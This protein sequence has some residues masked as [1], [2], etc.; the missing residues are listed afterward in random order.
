MSK[1]NP[2]GEL[3]R[4]L[5]NI[6]NEKTYSLSK[7]LGY[8]TTYISKWLNGSRLP[9]ERSSDKV[10]HDIAAFF[11]ERLCL[12]NDQQH[13][14]AALLNI[15]PKQAESIS[16]DGLSV[17]LYTM[18]RTKYSASAVT[19]DV[20]E[21]TASQDTFS[22]PA[23][24]L[25]KKSDLF[26]ILKNAIIRSGSDNKRAEILS[27]VDLYSLFEDK[28]LSLFDQATLSGLSVSLSMVIDMDR[29]S[30]NSEDYF[31]WIVKTINVTNAPILTLYHSG[32]RMYEHLIIVRDVIAFVL[33]MRES[34]LVA[35]S[36]TTDPN[37]LLSLDE[38]CVATFHRFSRFLAPLEPAMLDKTI[39]H[40][41][42]YMQDWGR[43]L[44]Y[45]A[46]S[47]FLPPSVIQQI[48]DELSESD[49]ERIYTDQL[50]MLSHA[51]E[52]RMRYGDL[53]VIL[54]KSCLM[55]YLHTGAIDLGP[56]RIMLTPE[57][58]IEHVRH[59]QEIFS[60]NPSIRFSLIDD[61]ATTIHQFR[62]GV[63]MYVNQREVLLE[64]VRTAGAGSTYS[65]KFPNLDDILLFRRYFEQTVANKYVIPLNSE[66]LTEYMNYNITLAEKFHPHGF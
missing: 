38:Y 61:T 7:H 23:T 26:T 45:G 54:F 3:L 42:F 13:A 59:L 18:L 10:I 4:Q 9:S 51:W 20:S 22:L 31:D 25:D 44:L 32:D 1:S 17:V 15:P 48:I 12:H 8:D 5:L 6:T 43:I 60:E 35:C 55:E 53:A 27:T 52:Q 62:Y 47:L 65:H 11:A 57:Q 28:L 37:I 63:S 46:P 58:R 64:K 36:Y 40:V 50:Q 30:K 21:K 14:A 16:E 34:E 2:F 49:R 24:F 39:L 29:V 56:H 41:D 19:Q 33:V 66:E